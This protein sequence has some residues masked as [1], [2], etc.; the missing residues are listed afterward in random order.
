MNQAGC[1]IIRCV[2]LLVVGACVPR[3]VPADVEVVARL[4][5][6]GVY[7]AVAP[8]PVTPDVGA[9]YFSIRNEG[10]HPDRLTAVSVDVADSVTLHTQVVEDGMMRMVSLDGMTVPAGDALR[11]VPGGDH[12]MITGMRRAY[13]A[14]DS[15][16]VTITLERSGTV[17][18]S[19]PVVSYGD[20]AARFP[21]EFHLSEGHRP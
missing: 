14:G 7:D 18:F 17:T 12:V 13:D 2:G 11:M 21:E 15:L 10:E 9:L 6:M 3:D 20:L 4:G 1:W 5:S 19:V 8:A 16:V